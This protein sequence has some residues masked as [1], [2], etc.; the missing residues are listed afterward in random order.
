M[1]EEKNVT[2]RVAQLKKTAS[3]TGIKMTHQRLEIFREVIT[4]KVHP[5]A[6]TVFRAVREKLPTVSLDTVYRTLSMLRDLRMINAVSTPRGG[7]RF[8]GN[9]ER[10]H[11]Y[12]CTVCGK[13]ID[14]T[15]E[16]FDALPIPESVR[17]F[18]SIE[19]SQVEVRG[20]C[21]GCRSRG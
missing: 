13:I 21:A 16:E 18:G 9:T 17:R 11:H 12:I 19:A 15:D 14:F 3:A 6:E 7:T 8:D 20:V 4:S 2:A 5:D 10:H 1:T